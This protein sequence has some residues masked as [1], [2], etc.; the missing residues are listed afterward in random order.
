[1]KKFPM[2]LQLYS[3]RE[4]TE[5]DFEGALKKVKDLGY[6]GIEFAGLYGKTADEVKKLC[7]EIG[8]VPLS[9]HV[10][11]SDMLESDELF[12]TYAKIGC[13]FIVIPWLPEDQRPGTAKFDE[14]I[15][16]ANDIGK[17]ARTFGL[18]LCYHNHD[19]EFVK[20]DGEYALDRLYREVPA[21]LL[22]TE[23]D[24][25]WV[26]TGGEDPAKYLLKYKGR[27]S[28][29]H[30]K[31]YIGK[32]TG[33]EYALSYCSPEE[34]KEMEGRFEYRPI[35]YGVQRFTEILNAAEQ[36]GTEWIIVEQDDPTP[37]K[38]PLECAELSI[39]YLKTINGK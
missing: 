2:A 34:K 24:T 15:R 8:L 17:R 29:V 28:I 18:T 3:V 32:K 22:E 12:K 7:K 36:A 5:K 31:D 6:D 30:L 35:G 19:F 25:C 14:V 16:G 21:E 13:R 27:A 1:M 39:N 20:A 9:A 23:L 38:T 10:P 11:F 26:N 33:K 4:E 37:G